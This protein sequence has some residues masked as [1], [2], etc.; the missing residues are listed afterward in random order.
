[1]P[2]LPQY[3]TVQTKG[4]YHGLPV[5]PQSLK[6]LSAIVTGANG[7]SGDHMMRVLA[8]S[9]ER[10]TNIYAMS[11][12]PPAA[13]RK[14]VANFKHLPLDFLNSSPEELAKS[15]K[16]NGVKADYV[17]FFSYVQ[18]EPKEGQG[19]WSDAEEM[20]RVNVSL[21]RN[22]LDALK[23]SGIIPK[24]VMLQTGAKNYG[25]HLGPTINP[26]H[27]SDPRVTLES[28]FYYPQEDMLFEYCRQTGAG[29]NVVRP[30]SI[31]GAVKDAAMNLV[32]PLGVFGAVQSYLGKPMVYP[33]DLNSFQAV[34]DMSTA[35]MNGYLEE[36]AVLTPAAANEA[37]NACDNSQFTF[38]KFWLRLAKWYGVGYEL[39]DE[40]AEYQAVQ[41]PYEPPPRGFGPRATHRFRYTFSEWASKP[42]VQA[43]WKDLMKKHNLE[44]NPFSNEKN[45]ERIFGFADGMMLGVTALQFNMDKAH[46]LGFFGTVDTV[47][48]MR[49]VL[50][51]FAELKMLPP[52]RESTGPSL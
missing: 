30:S 46:K 45:R 14:W 43:A 6:G 25:V 1:M 39:P 48:S 17:F 7:I 12:R 13:Q 37:F 20:T 5:F 22:F 23:L 41:T 28:N 4:I 50:E 3:L 29:W 15:M 40:N 2:A 26:Q 35:M 9:P 42:E 51:E 52:L 36:W 11:R 24:R 38:G 27:E 44:S 31:L 33:G 47:E 32:Y 19:L 10:W 8:E 34:Q 16:D 49:K 18:A 21:L